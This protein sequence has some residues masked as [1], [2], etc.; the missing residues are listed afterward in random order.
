MHRTELC[1]MGVL[2]TASLSHLLGFSFEPILFRSIR[3]LTAGTDNAQRYTEI[4]RNTYCG[5]SVQDVSL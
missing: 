1:F 4:C 2:P 3:K 5:S